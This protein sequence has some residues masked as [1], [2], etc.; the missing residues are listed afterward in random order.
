MIVYLYQPSIFVLLG[1]IGN[2]F[3]RKLLLVTFLTAVFFE[4]QALPFG[5][6][7]VAD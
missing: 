3:Q 2:I 6:T 4:L 1:A 5:K 7:S